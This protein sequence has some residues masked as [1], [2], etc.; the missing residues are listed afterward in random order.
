MKKFT[1]TMFALLMG[2]GLVF[3]EGGKNQ[4]DTGTGD[5]TTGEDAQGEAEQDQTGRSD[6]DWVFND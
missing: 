3:A 5:T 4:G 1:Y 6:S 2:V